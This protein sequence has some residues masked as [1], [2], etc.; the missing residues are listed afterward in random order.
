VGAGP[1]A[2]LFTLAA[3]DPRSRWLRKILSHTMAMILCQ[4]HGLGSLVFGQLVA[5]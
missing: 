3:Q 4:Q 5:S 1:L 2:S